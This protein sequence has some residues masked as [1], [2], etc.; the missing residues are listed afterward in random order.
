MAE[1][2]GD[3]RQVAARVRERLLRALFEAIDVDAPVFERFLRLFFV[4]RHSVPRHG[5]LCVVVE[6]S[7]AGGGSS[8]SGGGYSVVVVC[9]SCCGGGCVFVTGGGC[10]GGGCWGWNTPPVS[11][12]S[13]G[14]GAKP[15]VSVIVEV[16]VTMRLPNS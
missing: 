15:P 7:V 10:C 6:V 8:S 16:S 14:S 11:V 13:G 3:L 5:G 4:H 1:R 2:A 12:A 9:G